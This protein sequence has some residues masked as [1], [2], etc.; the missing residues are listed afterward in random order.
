MGSVGEISAPN[1]KAA[2]GGI[3]IPTKLNTS[4][5]PP[6]TTN[7]EIATPRV[8]R[9]A[10]A[11]FWSESCGIL[12]FRPPA[13]SRY[14]RSPCSSTRLKSMCLRKPAAAISADGTPAFPATITKAEK[15]R[16]IASTPMVEGSLK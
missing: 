12:R 6:A 1:N 16:A 14:A 15:I 3:G 4:H 11:P 2:T 7:V 5:V 8:E 13:N 9:R 10:I